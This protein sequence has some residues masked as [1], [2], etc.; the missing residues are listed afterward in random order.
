MPE[1]RSNPLPD[2]GSLK[3][4]FVATNTIVGIKALPRDLT[5]VA[6]QRKNRIT[7][8]LEVRISVR[9]SGNYKRPCF[10]EFKSGRDQSEIL[11][12]DSSDRRHSEGVQCVSCYNQM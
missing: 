11:H 6:W 3:G 4:R 10:R 8:L 9:F 7:L 1:S 5:H 12:R 2:N